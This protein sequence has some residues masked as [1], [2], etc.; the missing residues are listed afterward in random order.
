MIDIRMKAT[1]LLTEFE[2]CIKARPKHN[3]VDIQ[4]E[5]DTCS[6]FAKSLNYQLSWGSENDVAEAYYRL[7]PRLQKL[8]EHIIFD[9]LKH[10]TPK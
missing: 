4:I 5:K 3:A 9:V 7:E 2:L 8:K 10:G 6:S 1:E